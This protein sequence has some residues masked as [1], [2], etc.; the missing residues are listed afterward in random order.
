MSLSE[1]ITIGEQPDV[2]TPMT[3]WDYLFTNMHKLF[4]GK[5]AVGGSVTHSWHSR[6]LMEI[7]RLRRNLVG[8]IWM[9]AWKERMQILE[10]ST[11]L[12]SYI[13]V[14]IYI[15]TGSQARK[16]YDIFFMIGHVCCST[17]LEIMNYRW[18]VPLHVAGYPSTPISARKMLH[19]SPTLQ[20]SL[21][22]ERQMDS[23]PPDRWPWRLAIWKI[24]RAGFRW[25]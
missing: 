9:N 14:Y 10:E 5:S 24:P 17:R 3:F 2:M 13:Y 19:S 20:Q 15:Y 25:F 8:T 4:A 22:L 6:W 18:I 23:L 7:V 1:G 11:V 21:E 12:S 16:L